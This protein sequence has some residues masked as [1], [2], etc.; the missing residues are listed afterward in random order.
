MFYYEFYTSPIQGTQSLKVLYVNCRQM[1]INYKQRHK[2]SWNRVTDKRQAKP[3]IRHDMRNITHILRLFITISTL[4]VLQ[5]IAGAVTWQ[6]DFDQETEDNWQLQGSDSVWRIEEGFLRAKIETQKQWHTI[7]E[8]YQFM[9]FPGPYDD[10]IITIDDIGSSTDVR[11]GI[12]LGKRFLNDEGKIE[13][14]GYYLFFTNDMQASR[15][16]KIFLG[17]GKRWHTDVL[18]Q[19]VLQFNEGRFQLFGDGESRMDFRDANL[20]QVD[21]IGFILVGYVTNVANIGE[22]WADKITI[23]GLSVSPKRKLT[24]TWGHLKR[25]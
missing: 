20:L 6:D 15:D 12:A 23:S 17:P 16:G 8:L 24:T 18:N 1:G 11:F 9:E 5:G 3:H 7:F 14:T 13:E 4:L 2:I 21:I 22:V 10:L 19:L 25:E